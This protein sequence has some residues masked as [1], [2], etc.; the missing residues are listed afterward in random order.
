MMLCTMYAL[1][2]A[3][4]TKVH[5]P[6]QD[7]CHIVVVKWITKSW[8]SNRS[9]R[10]KSDSGQVG[11]E[12][13]KV[14]YFVGYHALFTPNFMFYFIR[15][16]SGRVGYIPDLEKSGSGSPKKVGLGSGTHS[17]TTIYSISMPL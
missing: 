17:T 3:I 12:F 1:L 16:G 7:L 2:C 10:K 15:S 14:R 13:E 6:C 8:V 11:W 5:F 9:D 4:W